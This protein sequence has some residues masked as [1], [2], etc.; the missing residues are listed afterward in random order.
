MS[1][2]VLSPS[3]TISE[4]Y[5]SNPFSIS[6]GQNAD[7]DYIT[8][9]TPQIRLTNKKKGYNLNA[10]YKI[11]S[12]SYR[13]RPA[14]NDI[15]H[16][17]GAGIAADITKRTSIDLNETFRA[18]KDSLSA[19]GE[20]IQ[21]SRS[22]IIFNTVSLDIAHRLG[23]AASLTLG[24]A[25]STSEFEDPA[26]F[27]TTTDNASIGVGYRF[28][29]KRSANL[30]Y[31]FSN[32]SFDTA[33]GVQHTETHTL[34]TGLDGRFSPT[35]S[36]ALSGGLVYTPEFSDDLDWTASAD[37]AK[38]LKS[39]TA[40]L[41]YMR[42]V[43]NSSGLSEEINFNDRVAAWLSHEFSPS[44]SASISGALTKSAS[45]PSGL[46]DLDT[47]S[48]DLSVSWQPYPWMTTGLGYTKFSQYSEGSVGSDIERDEAYL[49]LTLMPQKWRL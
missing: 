44:I 3:I 26:L 5:N 33:E 12:R 29:E 40:S 37:I 48:A 22:D 23:A 34:R 9:I 32:Y 39:T 13:D 10:F 36:F 8:E 20:D 21:T 38:T 41:A 35:L 7:D 30:R 42:S 6:K 4:S 19:I 31:S 46:V 45:K 28:S 24:A 47:Y 2:V 18:T 1:E 49:T 15:S 16:I 25:N 14:N 17:A 27:D 43:S 11:S